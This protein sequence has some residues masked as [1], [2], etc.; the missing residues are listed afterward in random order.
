MVSGQEENRILLLLASLL[1]LIE[2]FHHLNALE[3]IPAL[4]TCTLGAGSDQGGDSALG[5]SVSKNTI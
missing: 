5:Q 3:L 2:E 4:A 1:E